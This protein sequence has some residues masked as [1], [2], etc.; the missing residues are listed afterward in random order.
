MRKIMPYIIGAGSLA[1]GCLLGAAWVLHMHNFASW[2]Q[3]SSSTSIEANLSVATLRSIR[4]GDTNKAIERLEEF[5]DGR[6]LQL[7]DVCRECPRPTVDRFPFEA[8]ERAREYR[9][10][11]PRTNTNPA[12]NTAINKA[13]GS[14]RTSDHR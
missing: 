7:A 10:E 12:I 2:H 4:A 3:S 14:A 1:A 5:L 8:L 6:V 9:G 11:F 13:F